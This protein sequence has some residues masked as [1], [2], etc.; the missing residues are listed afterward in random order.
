MVRRNRPRKRT[1]KDY[2]ERSE[3]TVEVPESTLRY[4]KKHRLQV[5]PDVSL[6]IFILQGDFAADWCCGI[7]FKH[8]YLNRMNWTMKQGHLFKTIM[9]PQMNIQYVYTELVMILILTL[10]LKKLI[11]THFWLTGCLF[12]QQRFIKLCKLK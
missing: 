7:M 12:K 5:A 11:K 8:E 9:L 10:C 3:E 6:K 4:I 2:Y 1:Y